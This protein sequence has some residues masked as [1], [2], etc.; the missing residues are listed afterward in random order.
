MLGIVENMADI[1][2]P[3]SSL[4]NPQSGIK[5]V[6]KAGQDITK[7]TLE[8]IK[9]TC[10]ELLETFIQSNLFMPLPAADG[11]AENTPAA[12]ARR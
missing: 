12:M 6:N 4:A 9:A 3:L 8:K 10:P 11:E 1:R 7:E 2:L 5:M